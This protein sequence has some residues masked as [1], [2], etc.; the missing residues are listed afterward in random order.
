[1]DNVNSSLNVFTSNMEME[2]DKAHAPSS[3]FDH[4]D[5]IVIDS[6]YDN[7]DENDT[8]LLGNDFEQRIVTPVFEIRGNER[9][10]ETRDTNF[11][12]LQSYTQH[13]YTLQINRT[14]QGQ[15]GNF[16]RITSIKQNRIS[17]NVVIES[18]RDDHRTL[19]THNYNGRTLR[20]GKTVEL[21]N[22][23][24]VKIISILKN[25]S[26]GEISLKGFK[27]QR[28]EKLTELL[29]LK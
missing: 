27:F 20:S 24:F 28:D 17:G 8:T 1:M 19:Q 7:G 13:G 21:I 11:R 10:A 14:V 4:Q 12:E 2:I 15:D 26:I 29:L 18:F 25:R 3:D 9:Q 5:P 6:D 23:T 22:E 16:L